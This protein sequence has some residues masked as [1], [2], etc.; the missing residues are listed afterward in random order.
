MLKKLVVKN[1]AILEDIEIDFYDGLT[2]LTGETGAGKSLI[3]D[4]ISLL[5]GERARGRKSSHQ[6]YFLIF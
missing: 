1:F 6:W 5:L 4:S 3:I 2:I